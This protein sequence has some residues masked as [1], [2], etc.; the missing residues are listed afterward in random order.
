[1]VGNLQRF[2][3]DL[4]LLENKGDL[5][6]PDEGRT[7]RVQRRRDAEEKAIT[8]HSPDLSNVSTMSK[9]YSHEASVV[10]CRKVWAR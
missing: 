2:R 9:R 8:G 1:M 3:H 6:K 10:T 4:A 5:N 7:G